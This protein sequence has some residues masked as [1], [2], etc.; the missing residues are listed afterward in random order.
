V[1]LVF[2]NQASYAQYSR[3]ELGAAVNNII[4]YY[5]PQ[6]NRTVM[7]DLTGMQA[8]HREGGSRGSSHDITALL[9]QPQA[10]PLVAT[11]VHEATHQI[12]F[13]CGLQTRL[14]SNPLW[15]SEGLANYFETPDLASSRSWSGIGN[16]NYIRFDRYIDNYHA[17]RIAPL[18]QMVGD[19]QLFRSPETAVDAYAQAWAWNYFLIKW[20]PKQYVA[21]VKMLSEKPLL[22]DDNPKKRLADFRKHFGADL[23]ELEDEFYRRMSR[24]K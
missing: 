18:A 14:V 9:S 13:N 6:T 23:A 19:D 7:Y 24:V 12:S 1:V 15:L 11:I 17:G 10:E 4:G 16:V 21:Y 2:A 3:E 22:G 5:S 20:K 8:I